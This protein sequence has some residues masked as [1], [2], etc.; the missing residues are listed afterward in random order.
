MKVDSIV[1]L[2]DLREGKLAKK[3]KA[4]PKANDSADLP[5]ELVQT[6]ESTA[7]SSLTADSVVIST[8]AAKNV[9]GRFQQCTW[10]LDLTP[11]QLRDQR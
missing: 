9:R 3:R 1:D 8:S 11:R 6:D 4:Y 5:S 10:E 7:N 2:F